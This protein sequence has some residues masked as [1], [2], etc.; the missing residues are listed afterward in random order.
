MGTIRNILAEGILGKVGLIS[1]K[2]RP[3]NWT[4]FT[5]SGSS[6]GFDGAQ[7]RRRLA[8]WRPT[9]NSINAI[10]ASQGPLLRARCRDV[11]RN[12]PHAVAGRDNFVANLVGAGIKPSSLLAGADVRKE[13][14][15]TW[16]DWVDEA[17]ADG[18]TDFYG[19]QTTVA[20][21]L[22]EAGE[23]FARLRTRRESDGLTVPL[24][25]E[26]LESEMCPYHLNEM[27]PNGNTI[28]N[29]VEFDFRS[30]RVAYWF[31]PEH[32]GDGAVDP[33][34]VQGLRPVR[35]PADQ[36]IH[37][38]K[39]TRPGQ[40]RGVPM[41]AP[42]LVKLFF[43]DQYDD[44]E[45]ERKKIA[46]LFAG[47]VTSAAPEDVIPVTEDSEAETPTEAGVALTGLEPGTL[48]TLLPGEDVKFSEPADVGGSYEA[49][50]YRNQ[51]A[52]FSAMGVPYMLGTGD[53]RRASYS[54]LRGV[55]V[56]YRR[57]LEQVQY[58]VIVHQFCRPIWKRWFADAV[59]MEAIPVSL[60]EFTKK[61]KPL[62]RAKWIAPRFEWVDP[63]KDRQAEKLAV[64]AGFKSRS[65]VVEA[66]GYDPE[67][68]DARIKADKEREERLGL[69][70]LVA[71]AAASQPADP[72][73][74]DAQ[75]QA[76]ANQDLT[77][78]G[79]DGG[80]DTNSEAA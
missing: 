64:D 42:S 48:Q 39:A 61:P 6:S 44:A 54:S 14:M 23:I 2:P 26:L 76:D 52:T 62:M 30:R 70:F 68:N 33:S 73:A 13:V 67:E 43:L 28:M 38:F 7:G 10:I 63:L 24:Q 21:A 19:L 45:L 35:V 55:I 32:P 9:Q 69:T 15:A 66:E 1:N 5:V 75:E 53:T 12:N 18:L 22:F 60:A 58:N 37:V 50:Q 56:E 34:A 71:K 4:A 31:Y 40:V 57:K 47:F 25:I 79:G 51:L 29:G 77:G 59:L 8:S 20:S 11:M 27:A 36:V 78:D 3:K 65:D 16:F 74:P 80:A 41:V 46:A 49:F 17:D 72:N